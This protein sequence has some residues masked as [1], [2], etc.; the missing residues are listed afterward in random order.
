ML[1]QSIYCTTRI[2]HR[3]FPEALFGRFKTY[4]CR[5]K[6]WILDRFLAN[7]R[8]PACLSLPACLLICIHLSYNSISTF[9]KIVL[10]CLILETSVVDILPSLPTQRD[11]KAPQKVETNC[12]SSWLPAQGEMSTNQ[13]WRIQSLQL[14]NSVEMAK[15][16]WST[17]SL[18][19]SGRVRVHY[20]VIDYSS[21]E[22][23]RIRAAD[24]QRRVKNWC[25]SLGRP[26]SA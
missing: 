21:L 14:D 18:N 11:A 23:P 2:S 22:L 8:M 25:L 26:R 5:F 12:P 20:S 9:S 7:A 15:A 3:I 17:R 1:T 10:C 4:Q 24:S 13:P 19:R 6:R 16:T